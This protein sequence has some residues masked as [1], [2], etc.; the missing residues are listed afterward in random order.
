[1]KVI[2]REKLLETMLLNGECY[3]NLITSLIDQFVKY[4]FNVDLL[5]WCENEKVLSSAQ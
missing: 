5:R 2:K 3:T 4:L 1:M